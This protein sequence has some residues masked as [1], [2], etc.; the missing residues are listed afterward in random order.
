MPD[1]WYAGDY[2]LNSMPE[3]PTPISIPGKKL[4]YSW[5]GFSRSFP[6]KE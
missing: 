2:L 4:N 3:N 1:I 5:L 6:Q